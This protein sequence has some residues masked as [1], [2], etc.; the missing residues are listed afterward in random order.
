M[1]DNN[2]GVKFSGTLSLTEWDTGAV[3]E[4]AENPFIPMGSNP[5]PVA[6]TLSAD[7]ITAPY[8]VEG[9]I[10]G[11]C[12]NAGFTQSTHGIPV[13]GF[14]A[15]PADVGPVQAGETIDLIRFVNRN[16]PAH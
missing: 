11:V 16:P 13:I 9:G 5:F 6:V 2:R 12:T 3:N 10:N 15:M 14:S 7:A 4:I 8:F 1:L